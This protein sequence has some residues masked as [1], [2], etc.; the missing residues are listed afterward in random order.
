MLNLVFLQCEKFD[1]RVYLQNLKNPLVSDVTSNN[2]I[3]K[4]YDISF[5]DILGTGCVAH[6]NFLF[7]SLKLYGYH[8]P[9]LNKLRMLFTL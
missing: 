3:Q 4:C 5:L 8:N 2:C 7:Q 9:V 1:W 6:Y